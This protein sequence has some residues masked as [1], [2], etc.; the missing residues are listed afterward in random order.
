[1]APLIINVSARRGLQKIIARLGCDIT[2]RAQ[3]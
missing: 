1:M 3:G 2:L